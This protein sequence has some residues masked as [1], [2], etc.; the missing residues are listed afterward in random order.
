[1]RLMVSRCGGG[2]TGKV[3]RPVHFKISSDV[4]AALVDDPPVALVI[5]CDLPAGH[6]RHKTLA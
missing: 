5:F 1:M 2:E 6:M 4:Q 3:T